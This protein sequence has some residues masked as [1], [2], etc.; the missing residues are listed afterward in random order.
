MNRI[1][2]VAIAAGFALTSTAPAQAGVTV[3]IHIGQNRP[4]Y[5]E[6]VRYD[7]RRIGFD[8]GYDDGLREGAKDG[9]RDDRFNYRDERAYR[10]GDAGYRSQYGHRGVYVDAYR[11]GFAEGY[12]AAYTS[13]RHRHRDY[14]RYDRDRYDRDN[15][16]DRNDRRR[17][18]R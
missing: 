11:Q 16:N 12:R 2:L 1:T 9:R 15:F 18:R 4:S 6:R 5:N 7:T 17:D 14:D 10:N 13:R 8:N 3:G